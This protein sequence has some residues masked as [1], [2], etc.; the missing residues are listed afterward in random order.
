MQVLTLICS[1]TLRMGRVQF[2]IPRN[3]FPA[4]DRIPGSGY[5]CRRPVDLWGRIA[6]LHQRSYCRNGISGFPITTYHGPNLQNTEWESS[7]SVFFAR[8]I[9]QFFDREIQQDGL[10]LEYEKT[11][12]VMQTFVIPHLFE[13]LQAD[14]NVLKPCLIHGDLWEGN[15]GN[16]LATEEPII[17]DSGAMY[18]H[19][20]LELGMWRADIIRFG[21]VWQSL[22][23][24]IPPTHASQ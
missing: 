18:A 10:Y 8:L 5:G 3:I 16:N 13:P 20:E 17:F 14:G 19:N 9:D 11:F 12:D 24:A 7:W 23:S 2:I 21:K 1:K 15:V 6:K 22:R 4:A